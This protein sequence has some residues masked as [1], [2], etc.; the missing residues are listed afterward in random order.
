MKKINTLSKLKQLLAHLFTANDSPHDIALGIGLGVFLGILPGTGPVAALLAAQF[1]RI[2]RAAAFFGAL[3][4]NTWFSLVVLGLSATIG[5][6]IMALNPAELHQTI[7]AAFKPFAIRK[8]FTLSFTQVLLPVLT[9]FII[10][11][12]AIALASYIAAYLGVHGYRRLHKD[13]PQHQP[14]A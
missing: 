7:V 1:L 12:L 9:G 11:S 6:K 3:L 4:T 10:V 5:A 14:P 8:L 2:N 13:S